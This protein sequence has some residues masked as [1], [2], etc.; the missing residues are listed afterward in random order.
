VFSLIIVAL[1][2]FITLVVVTLAIVRG[3][4]RIPRI[5]WR[6][7]GALGLT[8]VAAIPF[9]LHA[10][11]KAIRIGGSL[12]EQQEFAHGYERT[13]IFEPLAL[14]WKVWYSSREPDRE[15]SS[16]SVSLFG[17]V[18]LSSK[19]FVDRAMEIDIR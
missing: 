13:V 11:A 2:A 17:H 4:P 16:V 18:E 15:T 8:I 3:I 10:R 14:D 19:Y 6:A 1:F 9:S 7:F 5:V 12:M